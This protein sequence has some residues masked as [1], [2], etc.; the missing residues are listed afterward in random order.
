MGED[1]EMDKRVT[2]INLK[3]TEKYTKK[4][5]WKNK[6]LY[7]F[8]QDILEKNPE[9]TAVVDRNHRLTFMDIES[10]S[11]NLAF[12]LRKLGI[13]RGDVVSFALP[14]WYHSVIIN[15]TLTKL[16]VVVN[17]IPLI[18]RE[19]EV[20]F[21]LNDA[22]SVAMIVPNIFRGYDYVAML[23]KIKPSLPNLKHIIVVGDNVPKG[24]IPMEELYREVGSSLPLEKIDP[25][26]VKLILYTSGTTAEPKGVQ[27]THNT[28]I[29][30]NLNASN[31]WGV[32]EEDVIFMPSPVTHVTGYLYALELPFI[33]G[34][35]V[36]LMDLWKPERALELMEEEKC[37]F[38]VGATPFLQGLLHSEEIINHDIGS[39]TFVCGGASVPPELIRESWNKLSWRA[40]RV[41]GS[42]EVPTVT[43]GISQ[44]GPSEKAAETD[45]IVY[46]N[47]IKIVDDNNRFLPF[48]EEGEIVVQGPELFLGYTDPALNQESF[49]EEGWFHT[50]DLGRLSQDGYLEITGRKKDIIIRG[51]EN[52]SVKEIEDLLHKHPSIEVAVVVAMPDAKMGEKACAYV[53]LKEGTQL[54]FEAMINFLLQYKIAKQKLPERLEIINELPMTPSGKIKK[55]E[56]RK[57]IANKVGMSAP[58]I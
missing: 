55:N 36:V 9:K 30:E 49:D 14:N 13:K 52:I 42:T 12:S 54:S 57:D 46:G 2:R 3:M 11:N 34:S 38:T 48:G 45:G 35:K 51:G 6:T 47:E 37:T 20:L 10:L 27:H 5:H 28:L 33:I 23:E 18:Y 29:C 21:I 41:Y 26:N 7:D 58:R 40:F 15:M 43:Y 1:S 19:R 24:S 17:P 50:G 22:Q 56:L 31:F 16:G 25:N 4:G 53:K 44:G 8:F 39:L 32:K